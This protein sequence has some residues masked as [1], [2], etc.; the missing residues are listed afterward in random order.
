M[1]WSVEVESAM[2]YVCLDDSEA[3]DN[4]DHVHTMAQYFAVEVVL[5]SFHMVSS[6]Q[7]YRDVGV[8]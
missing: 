5:V 3:V 8:Q 6:V 2:I 7:Y 4:L 1:G